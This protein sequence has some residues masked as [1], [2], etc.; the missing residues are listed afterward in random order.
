[1]ATLDSA[2]INH[3][4]RLFSRNWLGRIHFSE[5]LLPNSEHINHPYI[6]PQIIVV[7]YNQ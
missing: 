5:A 6:I 1:M 4:L 3:F 7:E 2:K